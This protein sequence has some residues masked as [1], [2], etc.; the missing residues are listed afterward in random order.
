MKDGMPR[1]TFL[2][3]AP[4]AALTFT[5][6]TNRIESRSRFQPVLIG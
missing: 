4:I 6:M 3:T 5:T 2:R 1:C